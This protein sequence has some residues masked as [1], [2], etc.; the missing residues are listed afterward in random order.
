MGSKIHE[1]IIYETYL[2]CYM[3]QISKVK[4]TAA[5][6]LKASGGIAPHNL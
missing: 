6:S 2:V 3:Q 4:G 1:P 5:Y